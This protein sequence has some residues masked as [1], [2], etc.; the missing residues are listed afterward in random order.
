[1]TPIPPEE[2]WRRIEARLQRRPTTRVDRRAAVGRVLAAPLGATVDVPGQDVSAM[3]GFALAG[4]VSAGDALPV[5]GVVAAGDR[6]GAELA[7]GNA[8]RIMTGAPIP[9]GCDRVIPI[10]QTEV[11]GDRVVV[12][13]TVAAGSWI[14]R[15]GEVL[16]QG[17]T[18]LA[19]GSLLTPGALSLLATHGYTEVPVVARPRVA[20][21][22][23]GDEVVPPEATPLPGQLRDS[24]TDFLLG[25]VSALGIEGRSLGIAPD[26]A[27]PLRRL[28]A[29]GLESD[30]LLLTGGVSMGEFDLVEDVLEDLGCRPLYDSVAIQPGK[31]MV[32]A[33]HD[34]GLV[35]ALPGNPASAMVCYWLL[36]RPA[37]RRMMGIHTGFWAEALEAT[38]AAAAPGA[39]GRD[40][41]LPARVSFAGGRIDV[42]PVTPKGSHDL[43][44]YA[45]GTALLRIPA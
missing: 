17:A 44:S 11:E 2:A 4:A 32:A 43:A 3:D 31:P 8:L 42:S 5:V 23:T 34:R 25:A 19:D 30:V 20:V 38:L 28:V 15:R 18:L 1:M 45:R 41:L 27:G 6:P 39:R 13:A 7:R 36:V 21:L 9:D 37:L 29:E 16:A 22:T 26:D 14:R 24:H 33:S 12:A 40:R 10:E 35:F